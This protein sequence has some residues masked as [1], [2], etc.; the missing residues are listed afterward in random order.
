MSLG[1][2]K[3]AARRRR[4]KIG[5]EPPNGY[6]LADAFRLWCNLKKGRIVS[7]A[8]ERRK[9]ERYIIKPQGMKQ[10][11][12]ITDVM[13][14]MASAPERIRMRAGAYDSTYGSSS[15]VSVPAAYALMIIKE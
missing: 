9:L 8:D 1:E 12:E 14:V 5:K 10:I 7:Y 13:R 15:S 4:K 6:V 11:D 3:Q 2:A